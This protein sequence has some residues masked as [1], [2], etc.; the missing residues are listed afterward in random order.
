MSAVSNLA[1]LQGQICHHFSAML[2]W[3]SSQDDLSSLGQDWLPSSAT[4]ELSEGTRPHCDTD[5][6]SD[7][8]DTSSSYTL[9]AISSCS[10]SSAKLSRPSANTWSNSC[11]VHRMLGLRPAN[12][13]TPSTLR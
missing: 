12:F 5:D 13:Q 11:S 3:T 8:I 9:A 7:N 2:D 10:T 1:W 6:S 4:V